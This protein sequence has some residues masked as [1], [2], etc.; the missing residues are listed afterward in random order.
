MNTEKSIDRRTKNAN[1]KMSLDCCVVCSCA[2]SLVKQVS[3]KKEEKKKKI[4][5]VVLLF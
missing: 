4:R 5:W 3:L 1:E 2:F